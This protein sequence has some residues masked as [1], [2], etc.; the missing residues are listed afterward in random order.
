MHQEVRPGSL[1]RCWG[2]FERVWLSIMETWRTW[3]IIGSSV[4]MK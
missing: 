4:Y 2:S 1:L 3:I